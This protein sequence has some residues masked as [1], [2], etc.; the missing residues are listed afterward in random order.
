MIRMPESHPRG[1]LA[2]AAVA[3]LLASALYLLP[4]AEAVANIDGLPRKGRVSLI[5]FGA[6]F[7][8]PCRIM[9]PILEK[10]EKAYRGRA[11]IVQIDVAAEQSAL[12]RFGVRAIPTMLFFDEEG[13]EVRRVLGIMEEKAIVDQFG[14]MGVMPPEGLLQDDSGKP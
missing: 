4:T 9:R 11:D 5:E 13:K 8:A 12:S 7:C 3:L 6:D 1:W 2:K 10:L 14:R